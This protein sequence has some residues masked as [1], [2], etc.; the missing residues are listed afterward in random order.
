MRAPTKLPQN[1]IKILDIER[2]KIKFCSTNHIGKSFKFNHH[3]LSTTI[4]KVLLR[5]QFYKYFSC[6]R[7][8]TIFPQNE[9]KILEKVRKEFEFCSIDDIVKISYFTTIV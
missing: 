2:E 1:E 6:K 3:S 5:N 7:P 9:N 8:P 4:R